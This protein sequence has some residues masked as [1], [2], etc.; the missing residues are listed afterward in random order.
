MQQQIASKRVSTNEVGLHTGEFIT[1][2]GWLHSWREMGGV[3]FLVLR[4]AWGTLQ[5]VAETEEELRPLREQQA[6]ME[7]VISLSGQVV[8]MPQAPGGVELHDLHIEVLSPVSETP[9]VPLNKPRL[10]VQLTTLLDHAVVANRHPARRAILRLGAGAMRAFRAT[11]DARQFTEIQT[12]K[13]VAAATESGANVFAVDYFG[14][15]AYLAQ[16]PQFYKQIMVGVFERVYEVGPV[17]RAEPHD[18]TRHINEYVSLDAEMGFIEDHFTV[19]GLLREALAGMMQTLATEYAAELQLLKAQLPAVPT[20]IPHLHFSEA[21][22]LIYRLHKVDERNEPDL[23]PQ[24]ERWLGEWAKQEF[25]SDFLF[26]TGYPMRKRPFYTHP[27]PARPA[28]SN[29]FDLLFR[30]TE[31]VTGGQR[32]HRYAD[33]LAALAKAGLPLEPFETYL[34]AFRYG[35]P[36][37]GGFAIGLERLLMQL[38][39]LPN[40]RLATTFPR[41]LTRLTP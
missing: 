20:E 32:L 27:D 19:M 25:A 38:I 9:V 1:V 11:L 33:Y 26:V 7:S 37:H 34:E 36:P 35:M 14:H 22:E 29:S 3:S 17:F 41:D 18:T 12:P 39:G 15:Q 28:Y 24:G 30:G 8:A 4:D 13:L 5:A 16:S 6:G 2:A 23:S 21:Q 10:N 40:I 31:L